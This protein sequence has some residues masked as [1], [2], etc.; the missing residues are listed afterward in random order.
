MMCLEGNEHNRGTKDIVF[1][2]VVYLTDRLVKQQYL[3][4]KPCKRLL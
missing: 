3:K 2:V 1:F 4:S